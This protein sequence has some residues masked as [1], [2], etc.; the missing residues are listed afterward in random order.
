VQGLYSF[1]RRD[2]TAKLEKLFERVSGVKDKHAAE[3]E[4]LPWSVREI[5]DALVILDMFH[6]RDIPE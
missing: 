1:D 2:L 6:I 5:S 3:G 4:Q